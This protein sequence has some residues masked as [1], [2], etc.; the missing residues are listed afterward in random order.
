MRFNYSVVLIVPA[1]LQQAANRVS[2]ALGFQGETDETYAVPLGVGQTVTHYGAHTFADEPFI[3]MLTGAAQGQLPPISWGD[4]G[5]TLADVQAVISGLIATIKP[6][7]EMPPRA[8]FDQTVAGAGLS[9]VEV[10]DEE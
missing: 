4:Y 6:A 10:D 3:E 1:A 9:I 8:H 2:W 7:G 5:L